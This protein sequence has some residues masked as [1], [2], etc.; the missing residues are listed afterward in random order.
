MPPSPEPSH[1]GGCLS[2]FPSCDSFLICFGPQSPKDRNSYKDEGGSLCSTSAASPKPLAASS[3]DS[4]V[5]GV[6]H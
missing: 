3:R 1:Q 6:T 4:T 5:P 2:L